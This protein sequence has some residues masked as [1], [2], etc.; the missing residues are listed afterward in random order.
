VTITAFESNKTT[1]E[2]ILGV[3]VQTIG[4]P[5]VTIPRRGSVAAAIAALRPKQWL[6]NGLVFAAPFGAGLELHWLVLV[7][8]MVC[9]LALSMIAS[10]TYLVNDLR[11]VEADRVHPKKRFRPIAANELSVPQAWQLAV[12]TATV[13]L[14]LGY[15][16]GGWRVDAVL[17]AYVALSSA[18]TYIFKQQAVLDVAL[19]ALCF[20]VRVVAGAVATHAAIPHGMLICTGFGALFM[21]VGK[22][23]AEFR[24]LGDDRGTHR[25]VLAQYTESYLRSMFYFAVGSTALGYCW[26]AF[27]RA[28]T[29]TPASVCFQLSIVPAV[30]LLMQYTLL[31]EQGAGGSP[32]ELVLTDRRLQIFGALAGLLFV[33][34][35]LHF[36]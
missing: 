13:G 1:L 32:E 18:Y 11:D 33:I 24:T 21:V 4:M 19:V 12:A 35:G 14:A 10:A 25:K 31:V 20:I 17:V 30:I 29:I 8:A 16:V 2:D 6:K 22:R 28:M 15:L 34:G 27:E 9:F 36:T 23:Y 3:A 26:W 5:H 7:Q